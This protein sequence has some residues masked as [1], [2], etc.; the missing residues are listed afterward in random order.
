MIADVI[1][2]I[3]YSSSVLYLPNMKTIPKYKMI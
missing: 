2:N 3:L 1:S